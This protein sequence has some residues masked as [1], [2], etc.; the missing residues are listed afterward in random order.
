MCRQLRRKEDRLG[1]DPEMEACNIE[2]P[3]K[4]AEVIVGFITGDTTLIRQSDADDL[5]VESS[6]V[7][8]IAEFTHRSRTSSRV[9]RAVSVLPL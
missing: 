2:A 8:H 6:I 5:L 3:K 1:G 4:T 9:P 7:N